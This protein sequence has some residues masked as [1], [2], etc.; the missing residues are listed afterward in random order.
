MQIKTGSR[1]RLS[2]KSTWLNLCAEENKLVPSI[3][4]HVHRVGDHVIRV[5]LSA[6][7][8]NIFGQV[9]LNQR[10]LRIRE[11]HYKQA[12]HLV[13]THLGNSA[14]RVPRLIASDGPDIT[15]W[16]FAFLSTNLSTK[17]PLDSKGVSSL[18]C[19]GS[20]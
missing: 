2:M 6:N 16:E 14:I 17:S 13:N 12:S 5:N 1:L 20:L 9:N 18:S 11:E 10:A 3:V 4:R 7:E 8:R 15:V 19:K